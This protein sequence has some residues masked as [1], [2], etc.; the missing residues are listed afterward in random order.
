MLD[1]QVSYY[2][3]AENKKGDDLVN[4]IYFAGDTLSFCLANLDNDKRY[5]NIDWKS[6][7]RAEYV[8]IGKSRNI[9]KFE[10]IDFNKNSIVGFSKLATILEKPG[11]VV[12]ESVPVFAIEILLK[13]NDS[14]IASRTL[15]IHTILR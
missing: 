6:S 12:D 9:H 2:F 5:E 13:L 15:E 4:H 14:L 10:R 3:H 7:F 11:I 8:I 1:R